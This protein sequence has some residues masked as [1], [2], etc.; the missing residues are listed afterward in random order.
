MKLRIINQYSLVAPLM[1]IIAIL[2]ASFESERNSSLLF[3]QKERIY[4]TSGLF[5]LIEF[6]Q[7]ILLS[8]NVF[9]I[10]KYI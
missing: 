6:T 9:Y 5:S 4:E 1:L 7:L 8:L 3:L 2:G 10:F